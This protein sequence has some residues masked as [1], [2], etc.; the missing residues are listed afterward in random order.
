M[1]L[2]DPVVTEWKTNKA[3]VDS[4]IKSL[5][6]SIITFFFTT[7]LRLS[8]ARPIFSYVISDL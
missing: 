8:N 1:W 2:V 4:V 7:K 3:C 5:E 6:V